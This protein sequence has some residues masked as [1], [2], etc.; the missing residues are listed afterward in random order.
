MGV[1]RVKRGGGKPDAIRDT[2]TK[3]LLGSAPSAVAPSPPPLHAPAGDPSHF[4]TDPNPPLP[5]ESFKDEQYVDAGF[6]AF[7]QST[8]RT[9]SAQPKRGISGTTNAAAPAGSEVQ[10]PSLSQLR[11]QAFDADTESDDALTWRLPNG[12]LHN[13]EGPAWISRNGTQRW[14][15]H[16]VPYNIHG[17]PAVITLCGSEEWTNAEGTLH[18]EDGPCRRISPEDSGGDYWHEEYRINGVL[19]REDGPAITYSDGTQVWMKKGKVTR[20]FGPAVIHADGRK[21]WAGI[22]KWIRWGAITLVVAKLLSE[23]GGGR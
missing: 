11:F 15:H 18:R 4:I 7:Q 19:H 5:G 20:A 13:E 6:Q 14:F 2:S 17:G 10:H 21:E 1:E 8:Q 9:Q 22:G 12:H 23:R 16:N 3:Q